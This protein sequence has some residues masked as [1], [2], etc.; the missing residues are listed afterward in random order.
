M[1]CKKDPILSSCVH[2]RQ[3][4]FNSNNSH[5]AFPRLAG[6]QLSPQ[7]FQVSCNS[8]GE[9]FRCVFLLQKQ[10]V[11]IHPHW[12]ATTAQPHVCSV[13]QAETQ[14]GTSHC[15]LSSTHQHKESSHH[16]PFISFSTCLSGFFFFLIHVQQVPSIPKH[17]PRSFPMSGVEIKR[18]FLNLIDQ[19]VTNLAGSHLLDTNQIAAAESS[20]WVSNVLLAPGA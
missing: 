17:V 6:F 12:L 3:M 19:V 14:F 2:L 20:C 13:M 15:L 7:A 11:E 9:I 4:V 5:C 8:P 1:W 18:D 10:D 16:R